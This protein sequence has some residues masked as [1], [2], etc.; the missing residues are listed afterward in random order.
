MA[1]DKKVQA[2]ADV[3]RAMLEEKCNTKEAKK[4]DPESKDGIDDTGEVEPTNTDTVKDAS[5]KES[6]EK[7]K[8]ESAVAT[9]VAE[10]T[11]Q[12]DELS[13]DTLK[14]YDSK[15][16]AAWSSTKT[17]VARQKRYGNHQTAKGLQHQVDRRKQGIERSTARLNKE[18][19]E[20]LDELS[21]DTLSNYITKASRDAAGQ[22]RLAGVARH[23]ANYGQGD[24]DLATKYVNKSA[25]R[26]KGVSQAA[27]K[28]AKEDVD[29]DL[30]NEVM[31]AA[32]TRMIDVEFEIN[33]AAS[34][35][36]EIQ[37]QIDKLENWLKNNKGNTSS[38]RMKTHALNKR[39]GE[40]EK[41]R[42]SLEK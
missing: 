5:S 28:L 9:D 18:E 3:Y 26:L 8:K 7:K 32:R 22:S 41:K 10:E 19:T 16:R 2:V 40:L 31:E 27:D 1:I 37:A 34:T 11:E 29:Q 30:Y 23:S 33:E 6:G 20:Q 14:S 38:M 42:D 12:L 24:K 4:V 25:K 15:A 21:K 17:A 13:K 39:I 35:K 36:A